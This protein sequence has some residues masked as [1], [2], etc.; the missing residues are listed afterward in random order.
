[1]RNQEQAFSI[2]VKYE[3]PHVGVFVQNKDS[4]KYEKCFTIQNANLDYDGVWLLSAGTGV[5]NPDLITIEQFA[6][7][8]PDKKVAESENKRIMS[9]HKQDAT[10]NIA[11]KKV[12]HFVADLLHNEKS[13]INTQSFGLDTLMDILPVKLQTAKSVMSDLLKAMYSN[14]NY[15]YDITAHLHNS[16]NHTEQVKL[17][18]N[19]T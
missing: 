12:D 16:K 15:Y 6:L 2:K 1:M 10:Y 18:M 9:K 5:S 7:Y 3:H 13:F 4:G 17:V 11:S 14:L 8:N 19:V